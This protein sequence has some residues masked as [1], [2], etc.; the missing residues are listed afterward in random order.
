V[1]LDGRAP[2]VYTEEI[3][4]DF[5]DILYLKQGWQE[6]L[7]YYGVDVILSDNDREFVKDYKKGLYHD[8]WREVYHDDI[9]SIYER[10]Q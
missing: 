1:F 5:I 9:A 6:K 2:T 10:K 8:L 3:L 4:S 7:S